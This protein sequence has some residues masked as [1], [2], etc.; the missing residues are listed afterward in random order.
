MQVLALVPGGISDQLLFFP[1]L[2]HLKQ[3]FP[4]A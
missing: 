3:A 4:K 2:E 1:T